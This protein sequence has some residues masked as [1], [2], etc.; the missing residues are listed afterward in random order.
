MRTELEHVVDLAEA[1]TRYAPKSIIAVCVS[2]VAAT[3]PLVASIFR[4]THW[5]HPGRLIGSTALCQVI[6]T[7]KNYLLEIHVYF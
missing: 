2:P 1:C 4:R 5:Y 6:I 7:N 3:L